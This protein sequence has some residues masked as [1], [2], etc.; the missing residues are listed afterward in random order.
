MA[1]T[2]IVQVEQ[3]SYC[4]IMTTVDGEDIGALSEG[5][6]IN[7]RTVWIIR[8]V[9]LLIVLA[10][11]LNGIT[12]VRGVSGLVGSIIGLAIGYY[13]LYWIALRLLSSKKKSKTNK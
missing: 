9:L 8:I 3:T 12:A 7:R 2:F 5:R 1:L 10:S 11:G 13:V 4:R 6:V